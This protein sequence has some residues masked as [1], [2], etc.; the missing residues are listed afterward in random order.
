MRVD[1]AETADE[2]GAAAIVPDPVAAG[3]VK[4]TAEGVGEGDTTGR[5]EEEEA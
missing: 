4:T 5:L 2:R 3:V 1:V